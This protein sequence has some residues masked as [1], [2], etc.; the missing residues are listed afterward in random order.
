MP[1]VPPSDSVLAS[2][3][4]DVAANYVGI[5]KDGAGSGLSHTEVFYSTAG[6][7]STGAKPGYT[8]YTYPHPLRSGGAVAG[9]INNANQLRGGGAAGRAY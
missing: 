8:E 4:P 2:N 7:A 9:T 1:A 6:S 5:N 3:V